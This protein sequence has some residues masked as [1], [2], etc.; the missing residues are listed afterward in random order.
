MTRSNS[1][2]TRLTTSNAFREPSKPNVE[3]NSFSR[4]IWRSR[5][6]VWLRIHSSLVSTIL[7]I[8]SLVN[9]GSVTEMPQPVI[10]AFGICAP[11]FLEATYH[12]S[13]IVPAEPKRVGHNMIRLGLAR[14]IGYIIQIANR[15]RCLI[16][17]CGG[18][19]VF[20]DGLPADN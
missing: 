12:K 7:A 1:L 3:G 2:G 20:L 14:L 17:N 11:L 5:I 4:P 16:I 6:P 19:E 13:G 10:C 15:V 8:S 9:T 18:Q